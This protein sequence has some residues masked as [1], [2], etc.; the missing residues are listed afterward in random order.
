M[1]DA[2]KTVRPIIMDANETAAIIS[3]AKTQ[4]RIISEDGEGQVSSETY[5]AIGDLLEVNDSLTL[6]VTGFRREKVQDISQDDVLASGLNSRE[7]GQGFYWYENSW[8]AP[9]GGIF[10]LSDYKEAFASY[11]VLKHGAGAW[12]RN[13]NVFVIDFKVF[14]KPR[15]EVYIHPDINSFV[16]LDG[17]N[18]TLF[19]NNERRLMLSVESP[20]LDVKHKS[21]M[22]EREALRMRDSLLKMYPPSPE[23]LLEM[24][25][26]SQKQ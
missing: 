26:Q 19:K 5:L 12:E 2:K 24:Y 11:W 9:Y 20:E 16:L 22:L 17:T 13:N 23:L 4:H 7:D 10:Y 6:E 21:V 14:D 18:F 3:G 1:N 8:E 15:K 25:Q